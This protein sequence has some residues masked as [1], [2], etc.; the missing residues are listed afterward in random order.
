M[1]VDPVPRSARSFEVEDHLRDVAEAHVDSGAS[2]GGGHQ[3]AADF[4]LRS[5]LPTSSAA[6]PSVAVQISIF[7]TVTSPPCATW[8]RR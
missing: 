3:P 2:L 4:V 7:L 6:T 1:A 8:R 5:Q